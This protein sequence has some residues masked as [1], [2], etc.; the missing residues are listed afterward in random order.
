[1]PS[2]KRC[3]FSFFFLF[4]FIRATGQ[5]SLDS[6]F[7][8][9]YSIASPT[10]KKLW[11]DSVYHILLTHQKDWN[12]ITSAHSPYYKYVVSKD[13][14]LSVVSWAVPDIFR[15]DYYA[16]VLYRKKNKKNT[17]YWLVDTTGLYFYNETTQYSK[18]EPWSG[19]VYYDIVSMPGKHTCYLLLG[20]NGHD[21]FSNLKVIEPVVVTAEDLYFGSPLLRNGKQISF[22]KIFRYA[23]ESSFLL[24]Y[25]K[26]KKAIVFDHL[27]Y[28]PSLS[29][30][31]K[32]AFAVPDGSYDAFMLAGKEWR[33]QE[34]Y[35]ARNH[36]SI[37]DKLYKAP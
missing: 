25:D 14:L 36:P 22:R 21:I 17:L 18:E 15:Y 37:K 13:N 7:A 30:E 3:A 28:L 4:F 8:R 9:I 33:F 29:E 12:A 26:E 10:E 2:P 31:N 19:A 32:E 1:M 34:K 5:S 23:E 11:I 27:T 16:A 6:C 20:W 35:D 24:H